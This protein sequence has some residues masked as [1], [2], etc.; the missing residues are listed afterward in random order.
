MA[1]LVAAGDYA[2]IRQHC[3]RDVERTVAL[4]RALK[5]IPAAVEATV[6]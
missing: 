3:S 5:V 2:A 4:A 1:A 6:F